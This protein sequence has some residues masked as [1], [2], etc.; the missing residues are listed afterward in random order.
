MRVPNGDYLNDMAVRLEHG[1]LDRVQPK[2]FTVCGS[3]QCAR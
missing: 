3:V 2:P 1:Q